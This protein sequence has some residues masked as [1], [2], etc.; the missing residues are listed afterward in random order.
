M[1][2]FLWASG[3]QNQTASCCRTAKTCV[4]LPLYDQMHVYGLF[5][6]VGLAVQCLKAI[7][8]TFIRC[9]YPKRLAQ[10]IHCLSVF[11]FF[12]NWTHDLCTA[13][14]MLYHWATGTSHTEFEFFA[15]WKIN[16]TSHCVSIMLT[17]CLW[18]V[19]PS[20]KKKWIRFDFLCFSRT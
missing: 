16:T 15:C 6:W 18:N 9:F 4:S 1:S 19:R 5:S 10:V 11:V 20:L 8:F 7:A 12:G 2:V 13:N 14:S 17:D 3:V